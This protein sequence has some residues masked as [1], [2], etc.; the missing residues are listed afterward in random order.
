MT[1]AILA[2]MKYVLAGLEV[3]PDKMRHNLDVLG[4]FLLSERVMFALAEQ[5]RQ[6]DRARG[7]LRGLDARLSRRASPSSRR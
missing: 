5:A 2:K 7:G 3:N 6:A 1:G 4:G